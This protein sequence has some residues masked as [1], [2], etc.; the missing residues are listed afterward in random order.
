VQIAA[1]SS[2][3]FIDHLPSLPPS[4]ASFLWASLIYFALPVIAL[5]FPFFS[6]AMFDGSY[7]D[8]NPSSSG[9]FLAGLFI[10]YLNAEIVALVAGKVFFPL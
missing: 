8:S 4:Q 10:F 1:K 9:R 6:Y 5:E 7:R 3:S 2:G